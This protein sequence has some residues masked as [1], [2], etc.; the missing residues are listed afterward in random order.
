MCKETVEEVVHPLVRC[1]LCL[2]FGS[3]VDMQSFFT[4][5]CQNLGNED[6][7]NCSGEIKVMHVCVYLYVCDMW[8]QPG[9]CVWDKDLGIDK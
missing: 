1:D 7:N 8:A 3:V 4:D 5:C 6:E 9:K 2:I